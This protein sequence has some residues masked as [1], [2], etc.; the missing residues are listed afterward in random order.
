MLSTNGTHFFDLACELL[1]SEPEFITSDL[2][3]DYINPRDK[4]LTIIGGMASYKMNNNS[5]IHVSFSIE[6]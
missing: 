5:F 2:E 6:Q 1:D 3:I 4:T